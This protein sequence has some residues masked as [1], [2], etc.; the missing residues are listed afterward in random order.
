M[1]LFF[2][3]NA[4]EGLLIQVIEKFTILLTT[5]KGNSS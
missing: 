1:E 2:I 4:F 5:E 3:T